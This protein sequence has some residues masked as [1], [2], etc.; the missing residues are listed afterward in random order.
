MSGPLSGSA[1]PNLSRSAQPPAERYIYPNEQGGGAQRAE[2]NIGTQSSI[3]QAISSGF[4]L[5]GKQYGREETKPSSP[6]LE[7]PVW[8]LR[9]SATLEEESIDT[10]WQQQRSDLAK[11]LPKQ[12]LS[13]PAFADFLTVIAKAMGWLE[14][15]SQPYAP[16]SPAFR[17]IATGNQKAQDTILATLVQAETVIHQGGL[18]LK[19]VGAANPE[20]DTL[21]RLLT[22]AKTAFNKLSSLTRRYEDSSLGDNDKSLLRALFQQLQM[23]LAAMG[24]TSETTVLKILHPTLNTMI[25]S[26]QLLLRPQGEQLAEINSALIKA[27][28]NEGSPLDRLTHGFVKQL[29][30]VLPSN[31][32][33]VVNADQLSIALSI[34][35]TG[36]AYVM[37]QEPPLATGGEP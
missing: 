8:A 22:D 1:D 5:G 35:L 11:D 37:Q 30:Q 20:F 3:D 4:A 14:T 32:K 17:N 28:S 7:F 29:Q 21:S 10:N 33:T 2:L 6:A 19:S 15:V 26:I 13:D 16:D 23:I 18:F 36:S 25:L 9:T 34:L 24:S 12:L 31:S 27:G